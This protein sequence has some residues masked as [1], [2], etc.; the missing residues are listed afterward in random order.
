MLQYL[1]LYRTMQ[2]KIMLVYREK[3]EDTWGHRHLYL[4]EKF[5]PKTP[6][7]HRSILYNE[8]VI[9]FDSG[10]PKENRKWANQVADRLSEAGLEYAKWDSGNKSTHVHAFINAKNCPNLSLLK[11]SFMR[12]F[13]QGLPSNPDL[14]LSSDNHLIRAEYG[15]HEKTG[16]KKKLLYRTAKYPFINEVPKEVWDYYGQERQ[17][18]LKRKLTMTTKD[19]TQHEAIRFLMDSTNIREKVKDGRSRILFLLVSVLREK[20]PL[21]ELEQ[22]MV[23]WYRYS[24]GRKLSESKIREHVQYIAKKKYTVT[25]NTIYKY[26]EE[27]GID[28][29]KMTTETT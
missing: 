25:E 6:Y 1:R 22:F 11:S 18:L 8:V 20:M 28:T 9:E 21:P 24:D 4:S 12:H 27:I 15:V 26:C 17:R 29:T 5:S 13:C 14:R 19:L 2:D 3:P 7:N 23:D 16:K 10:T